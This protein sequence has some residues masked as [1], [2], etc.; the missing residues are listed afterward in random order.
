MC[1]Q[2]HVYTVNDLRLLQ[3]H[4]PSFTLGADTISLLDID[5]PLGLP[6]VAFVTLIQINCTNR[7][8]VPTNLSIFVV[9]CSLHVVYLSYMDNAD[10]RKGRKGGNSSKL[11][12]SPFFIYD[13]DNEAHTSLMSVFVLGSQ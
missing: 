4:S 3:I 11:K 6:M 8:N 2:K 5:T 13:K 9:Y 12:L 10:W 1:S 7:T